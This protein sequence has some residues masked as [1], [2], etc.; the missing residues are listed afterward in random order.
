MLDRL[1]K[2]DPVF[3]I[4]GLLILIVWAVLIPLLLL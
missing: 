4:I 1:R 3:L 2:I